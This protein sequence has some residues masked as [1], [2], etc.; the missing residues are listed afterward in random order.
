ML[1]ALRL[2][3]LLALPTEALN[4][5]V[6]GYPAEPHTLSAMGQNAAIALQ[7][8]LIHLPGIILSDRSQFFRTHEV[9][10]ALAFLLIGYINTAIV[11]AAVIFAARLALHAIHKL[12]SP[13]RHAH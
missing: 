2:P 3:L 7:W 10:C 11:L 5:W 8:Y 4:F 6:I 1:H 13:L 12:S 9:P